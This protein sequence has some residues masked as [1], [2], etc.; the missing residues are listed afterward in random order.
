MTQEPWLELPEHV[1]AKIE[2][3]LGIPPS[4]LAKHDLVKLIED[5]CDTALMFDRED[6]CGDRAQQGRPPDEAQAPPV[7]DAETSH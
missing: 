7:S 4:E 5:L 6:S 1:V 3:V 2:K